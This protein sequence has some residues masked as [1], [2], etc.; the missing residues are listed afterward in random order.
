M[1][2][3]K[4]TLLFSFATLISRILGYIRDLTV[5]Y[6]FGAN[7]YTDAFFI[8]WRLPNTF[9]QVLGEGSLNA[10]FIPIYRELEKNGKDTYRFAN[11]IFTELSL[12]LF[13][14]TF[15]FIFLAPYITAILAPGFVGKPVFDIA[16]ELVRFVF[17]Y[18]V[19][20][21]WV[22]F[23][24]ALLNIRGIFFLPAFTPAI[25][26]LSFVFSALLLSDKLGI[27]AL[28]VGAIVGGFLQVLV[29]IKPFFK[30]F[31][32][33]PAL[34]LDENVKKFFK[35]LFPTVASF[36]VTQ[37]GFVID[38]VIASLVMPGA[39]SYLYY[40]NRLLQ[41]PLGIFG[42]GLGNA[43][44]V[45]LSKYNLKEDEDKIKSELTVSVKLAIVVSLAASTGLI[46]LA[47]DI[48]KVLFFRGEFNL[49]DLKYT[50]ISLIGLSVGLVAVIVQKPIKSVYFA[51]HDVKTP[52]I[53][54][55]TGVISGIISALIFVFAFNFSVF[56]LALAT[57]VNYYATLFYLLAFLPVGFYIPD[58]FKT[59]LKSIFAV[60]F[61]SGFIL[62]VKF[63]FKNSL[64]VIFASVLA[65]AVI[66]IIFLLLL[67][68]DSLRLLLKNIR[69]KG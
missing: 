34:A 22:A 14:L 23:F 21:G 44:L 4:H 18:V 59:F 41:L 46:V 24:M 25:L 8:A 29:L 62:T 66:Y 61:M 67:K 53:A 5:A 17:P 45:S 28:A 30:R 6:I 42:I 68:E 69:K 38:T 13:L 48:V 1:K 40:A 31:K 19:F 20:A 57:S 2:F 55:L 3:I 10:V 37:V 49:E 16:V 32:L 65:G 52:L 35:R 11:T 51:L 7:I 9:R 36:G 60:I 39:I 64:L 27:Y 56:G 15:L 63:L 58:I 43:V 47:E 12:L 26:N 33:K 50:S 54:T